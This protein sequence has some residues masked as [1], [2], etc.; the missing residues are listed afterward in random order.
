M[1]LFN[2]LFELQQFFVIALHCVPAI[3]FIK[4]SSFFLV[5][6]GL[7]TL[8]IIQLPNLRLNFR[9]PQKTH[10]RAN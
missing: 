8:M 6:F 9:K 4:F 10:L 3:F 7:H 2:C 5:F 1:L